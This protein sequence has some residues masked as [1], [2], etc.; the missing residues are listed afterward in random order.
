MRLTDLG[1]RR[2]R[3]IQNHHNELLQRCESSVC[4][5]KPVSPYAGADVGLFVFDGTSTEKEVSKDLDSWIKEPGVNLHVKPLI[6]VRTKIDV[7]APSHVATPSSSTN[8]T[9]P[10]STKFVLDYMATN[11]V[12]DICSH[13]VTTTHTAPSHCSLPICCTWR[14]AVRQALACQHWWTTSSPPAA[15]CSAHDHACWSQRRK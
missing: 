4:S 7:A 11:A 13:L 2:Q 12:R 3:A 15:R 5:Q 8:G 9:G 10:A 6:V 14:S 1:P